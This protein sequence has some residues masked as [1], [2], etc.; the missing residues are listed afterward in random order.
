LAVQHTTCASCGTP[1]YIAHHTHRTIRRLDGVWRL[2]MPLMRCLNSHCASFRKLCRP[3]EEGAWALPHGEFG[4][5]VIALVGQLRY[6][7]HRSLPEIH[8]ELCARWVVIAERTVTNLLARYEE[9]VALRLTDKDVLRQCFLPQGQIILG[10]DGLKPDVGHE[11]LW[12]LRD[13]LSGEVLLA[14]SLLSEAEE[15]LVA[16][17][18]E[19]QALVP[20]PIIGVISDGQI[21]LRH[22][23]AKAFPNIPHQ[24]CQY[25]YLREAA[26]PIYEAD[27]HAKK[28]LK[29]VVRDIRPVERLMEQVL[30]H[31]PEITPAYMR[32]LS[33]EEARIVH[34]YCLAVRS[35]L[36]DD[37]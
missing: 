33:E 36:T 16:L 4:F 35:A 13:C 22:T 34:D 17:L 32:G 10:I 19:V 15:D 26:K 21:G 12:V 25:H 7:Q 8:Q 6:G 14:R 29:A 28:D 11:V 9:L 20:V 37:G 5:D 27:R 24:L 31:Q 18:Q 30:A 23:V 2:T 3:E 1:L